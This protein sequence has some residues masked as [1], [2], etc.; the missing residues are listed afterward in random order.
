MSFPQTTDTGRSCGLTTCSQE[1]NPRKD[2]RYLSW[3]D[4]LRPGMSLKL[5]KVPPKSAATPK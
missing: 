4:H 5:G 2:E 3:R 1:L